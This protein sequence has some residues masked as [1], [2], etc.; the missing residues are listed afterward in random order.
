MSGAKLPRSC[1]RFQSHRQIR[2]CLVWLAACGLGW[3]EDPPVT[4]PPTIEYVYPA[5]GSR[6]ASVEVTVAGQH[7][8][9]PLET[10]TDD[11]G[12]KLAPL[13]EAG[14]FRVEIG[15]EV[16][17]GPH[18]I[19]TLSPHGASPPRWF[20]V[21]DGREINEQEPNQ[22]ADSGTVC[23][24][25]PVIVNGRLERSGD[26]DAF[27]VTL[28][29]GD[30][31]LAEL[32]AH[33]MGSPLDPF[34]LVRDPDGNQAAYNHDV[35]GL[36][37]RLVYRAQQDG[38][39]V[40]QVAAIA[41]PPSTAVTFH[42]T[43]A[44]VYRL[45]LAQGPFPNL[46]LPLGIQRGAVT[47]LELI[48]AG[49]ESVRVECDA[50]GL[51]ARYKFIHVAAPGWQGS[52]WLPVG[53]GPE[54]IEEEPN[55]SSSQAQQLLMPGAVSGRIGAPR[56]VDR[57]AIALAKDQQLHAAVQAASLGYPLDAVL[58][59]E[60][61]EQKQLAQSDDEGEQTEPSGRDPQL[62]WTAPEEGT[63]F[64]AVQGRD[65]H[66]GESH[67][68]RLELTEV[69]PGVEATVT[70]NTIRLLP[71]ESAELTVTVRRRVGYAERLALAVPEL[72]AGV[73]ARLPGIPNP[74]AE[75]GGRGDETHELKVQLE[76][77]EKAEPVH[78]QFQLWIVAAV[79]E[80]GAVTE[81]LVSVDHSS[82][83]PAGD[84]DQ[85]WLTVAPPPPAE[86]V[87]EKEGQ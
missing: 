46:A 70:P 10:W 11:P 36:D 58:R 75:S 12:L 69:V 62:T 25:L 30:W 67:A 57:Y 54:A 24:Q 59:V 68:Y 41:Y 65:A 50:S 86:E 14:Q 63:Y 43:A 51:D 22:D 52:R 32:H 56:D 61:A 55:D 37:P 19:R 17:L 1:R 33:R 47:S 82:R 8:P 78:T 15:S 23:E 53:T 66:A 40:I 4:D 45:A 35:Y 3:A 42:G 34:L 38:Q 81:S 80:R 74:F 71:G 87:E 2:L 79:D 28:Q 29:A 77:D 83:L 84:L 76:A 20:W 9:W 49:G 16:P 13:E 72:P 18:L 5:G 73:T 39:H 60:N 21:S 31:L 48:S 27:V 6:G 85:V 7:Q 26:L 64:V 44:G